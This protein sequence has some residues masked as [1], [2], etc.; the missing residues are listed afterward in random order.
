MCIKDFLTNVEVRLKDLTRLLC[1]FSITFQ[2]L[3]EPKFMT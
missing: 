2:Y 1:L 3:S